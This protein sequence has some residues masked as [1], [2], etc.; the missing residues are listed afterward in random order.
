[1]SILE[2]KE[3]CNKCLKRLK[4]IGWER[5]EIK[6]TNGSKVWWGVWMN[7]SSI[8]FSKVVRQELIKRETLFLTLKR[9]IPIFNCQI[10]W[11]TLRGR[12]R[13]RKWGKPYQAKGEAWSI[14]S[15]CIHISKHRV[16]HLKYVKFLLV[17]Y[18]SIELKNKRNK[19][20]DPGNH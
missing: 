19:M 16:V 11:R 4:S 20:G 17:N 9:W 13:E 15:Q 18:T 1:M 6:A 3:G 14:V 7:K 8:L 5:D 2:T 10:S 12:K